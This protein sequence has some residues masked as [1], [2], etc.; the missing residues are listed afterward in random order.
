MSGGVFRVV[1]FMSRWLGRE[2]LNKVIKDKGQIE[3]AQSA[4]L[5]YYKKTKLIE[6]KVPQQMNGCDCGVFLLKYA[7]CV[8]RGVTEFPL[9]G[10]EDVKSEFG[11]LFFPTMFNR[12]DIS[13]K[14]LYLRVLLRR[15]AGS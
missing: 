11:R 7:E 9:A 5:A 14:R 4:V 1:T 15:L 10:A 12:Q 13:E 3:S 2:Y 8:L 6:P